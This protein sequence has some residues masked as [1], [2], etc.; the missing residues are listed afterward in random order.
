MDAGF[1]RHDSTGRAPSA[2]PPVNDQ[3][4]QNLSMAG[5]GKRSSRSARYLF[6]QREEEINYR[7]DRANF[8]HIKSDERL[9]LKSFFTAL[10]ASFT[11]SGRQKPPRTRA[12]QPDRVQAHAGDW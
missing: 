12:A 2:A 5:H 4:A 1:R 6:L 3:I 9:M 11:G 8:Y 7:A 10:Y